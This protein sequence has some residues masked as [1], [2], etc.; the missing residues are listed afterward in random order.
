MGKV[1]A[2]VGTPHSGKSVFL[3]ELYKFL[4]AIGASFFVQRACPD[5]EGQWSA[6]S[7]QSLVKQIRKKGKFD[8]RFVE[9]QKVAI[10][11]LKSN[12]DIVLVDLGGLPS[13]ENRQILSVCDGYIGLWRPDLAD[14]VAEW[15]KLL[16]ELK[17]PPVAEFESA[18]EGNAWMKVDSDGVYGRLARLDRGGVPDATVEVIRKFGEYLTGGGVMSE[19]FD[20]QVTEHEDFVL[21]DIA[22]GGNGII[23]PEELEEL[24][25]TVANTVGNTYHGKGVILSGRLPVWAYGALVHK[26]HPAK[27]V[28]TFD[29]RLKGGVV[30]ATHDSKTCI[31]TVIPL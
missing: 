7:D 4:R 25:N 5:G 8:Q 30:V 2:V 11:S 24:V 3:G 28:A 27:W 15:K 10:K 23:T 29:P 13:D 17:I 18:M 1:I 31:G 22:I 12:F 26:F 16:N 14:R 21:V 19:K 9:F 20:V 6:E